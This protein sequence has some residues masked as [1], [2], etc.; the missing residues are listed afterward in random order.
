[1]S[2]F[3]AISDKQIRYIADYILE[4]E[5]RAAEKDQLPIDLEEV[6]A[7]AIEVIKGGVLDHAN[8]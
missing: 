5:S 8:V 4:E 1:M 3:I 2:S 6:I 7:E